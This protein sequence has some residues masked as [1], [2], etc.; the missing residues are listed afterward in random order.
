MPSVPCLQNGKKVSTASLAWMIRFLF[1]LGRFYPKKVSSGAPPETFRKDCPSSKGKG[2]LGSSDRVK[3]SVR[4]SFALTPTP[5]A[6]PAGLSNTEFHG[7]R[8]AKT[9]MKA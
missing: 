7:P 1:A 4:T 3:A 6:N 9:A 5:P 8:D 2:E